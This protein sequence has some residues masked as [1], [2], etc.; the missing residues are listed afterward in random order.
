MSID[1]NDNNWKGFEE[2]KRKSIRRNEKEY[3]SVL[4]P[5][6]QILFFSLSTILL[7]LCPGIFAEQSLVLYLRK[8]YLT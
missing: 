7:F 5:L 6:R 1:E 3:C 2:K 8:M 4:F